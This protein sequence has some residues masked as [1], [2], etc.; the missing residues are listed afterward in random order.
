[1][2]SIPNLCLP[3]LSQI[4]TQCILTNNL[5]PLEGW[6][7][8]LAL[9]PQHP[10]THQSLF[11]NR[12]SPIPPVLHFSVKMP[13]AHETKKIYRRTN[14]R[15]ERERR[16]PAAA[17]PTDMANDPEANEI[18]SK[19]DSKALNSTQ[20]PKNLELVDTQKRQKR[21]QNLRPVP[22]VTVR[23]RK[24][25]RR[26]SDM[27]SHSPR[28]KRPTNV[29]RKPNIAATSVPEQTH[30]REYQERQ[31]IESP[32][33][34]VPSAEPTTIVKT[35]IVDDPPTN[36]LN[37]LSLEDSKPNINPSSEPEQTHSSPTT[38]E[39]ERRLQL[40]D[41]PEEFVEDSMEEALSSID[42]TNVDSE[43][44]IGAS[45]EQ[46]QTHS[47][48]NQVIQP[49]PRRRVAQLFVPQS[50]HN[51]DSSSSR[52]SSG[53]EPEQTHSGEDHEIQGGLLL[54]RSG[55]TSKT[56]D[57]DQAFNGDS[58]GSS[59]PPFFNP[60]SSRRSKSVPSSRKS[61]YCGCCKQWQRLCH[62]HQAEAN[63][64]F[65]TDVTFR[66]HSTHSSP[67]LSWLE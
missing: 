34:R 57:L 58:S 39:A 52:R 41:V 63:E 43:P 24:H 61:Y 9:D 21:K 17:A 27:T 45:S 12:N 40:R 10:K 64:T 62:R 66:T 53:N 11:P 54:D 32:I 48:E 55:D 65:R 59:S 2:V 7:G 47:G 31:E 23:K 20:S 67:D 6:F 51:A 37:R 44:N 36:Q 56:N 5:Y 28:A 1:M 22:Q 42:P 29:D 13:T 26:S 50:E 8:L 30:S 15:R 38:R 25:L 19:A 4:L 16:A 18:P 14:K 33:P 35:E 3:P 60:A 46:V 49:K